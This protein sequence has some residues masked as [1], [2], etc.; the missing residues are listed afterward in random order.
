MSCSSSAF[1]CSAFATACRQWRSSSAARSRRA[2]VGRV[3]PHRPARAR[4]RA[5]ARR[6]P[7]GADVLDEPP[8][9]ASSHRPP[10]SPRSPRRRPRRWRR[11]SRSSAPCTA[12]SSTPRWS[13]R[14]HGT[15]VLRTFLRDVCGCEQ[16]WTPVSIVD[17][18]IELIRAQ[19]GEGR[20][21]CGLSGGV[22]SSVAAL[23]VHRAL[24]DRL[25]CVLVD[26][27]LLRKDE[28]E[29]V[30]KTLRRALRRA[31]RA[32]RCARP[33]PRPPRRA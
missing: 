9:H 19:V 18:Q 17:E 21:I 3:R 33:L 25:V 15:D 22:D 14:P 7:A 13:T 1:R 5:S 20:A 24:G 27:G 32:R 29:Q 6:P 31:A 4:L 26:H 16:E 11:S 8:R 23:I 12:S 28:A 10:A 2:E 30:V